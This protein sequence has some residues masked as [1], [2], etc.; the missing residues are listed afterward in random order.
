MFKFIKNISKGNTSINPNNSAFEELKSVQ[1]REK[2]VSATE[3]NYLVLVE[4]GISSFKTILSKPNAINKNK[5]KECGQKLLEAIKIKPTNPQPYVYLS[6]IYYIL[7]N[8]ELASE[9]LNIATDLDS[10]NE[11]QALISKLKDLISKK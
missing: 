11:N 6:Y 5:L 9:Y 1:S 4:E 2:V 10:K 8:D 7:D 3:Q